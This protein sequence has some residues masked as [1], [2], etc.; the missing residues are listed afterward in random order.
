MARAISS[1]TVVLV[2]SAPQFPHGIVDPIQDIA[3]LARQYGGKVGV[4]VDCC[5]GGFVMAFMEK[6]GFDVEPFDFRVPGVTS[7]SADTHKYGYTPKGSSV[8][9]YSNKQL[10]QRQYFVDPNWPGG[11]YATPSTAGSRAGCLIATTWATMMYMG[12][13]GYVDAARRIIETARDIR[14]GLEGIK[15][16]QIMGDPRV[17]VISFRAEKDAHV[18][19]LST[20]LKGKGWNL[21]LLQFPPSIHNC[22]TMIQTKEGVVDRFVNDVKTSIEEILKT[23]DVKP[24][25]EAA[26]YGQ[27]AAIPDRSIVNELAN[28]FLDMMYVATPPKP[29]N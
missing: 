21:H 28:G 16:I 10:R 4:H 18:L 23:P 6:A 14:K 15:G 12:M 9:M 13:D 1:D 7:I 26:L 17:M 24:T 22:V 19:R 20:A 8:V 11:I 25:G 3:A 27:S 5:L 29:K 2:G